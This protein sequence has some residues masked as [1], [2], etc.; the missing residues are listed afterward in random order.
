M[1]GIKRRKRVEGW[2]QDVTDSDSSGTNSGFRQRLADNNKLWLLCFAVVIGLSLFYIRDANRSSA[3]DNASYL[4]L[5]NTDSYDPGAYADFADK[6]GKD[7]DYADILLES[8]RF[9]GPDKFK[10]LVAGDISRDDIEYVSRMA[11][12]SI[13]HKFKHRVTVQ[14][15]MKRANG[16]RMLV[17]Y[18]AWSAKKGYSVK[19][20]DEADDLLR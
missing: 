19:F 12:R 7:P 20:K 16:H 8:P 6:L 9:N 13:S 2:A 5:A 17:A 18:T 1:I 4:P 11:A 10:F 15:Y 3:V 14:A